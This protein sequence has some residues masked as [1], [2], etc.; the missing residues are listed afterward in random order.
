LETA[1]AQV[2][3]QHGLLIQDKSKNALN[4]MLGKLGQTEELAKDMQL[5]VQKQNEKLMIIDT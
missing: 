1:P 3:G 5:E 4:R 2:V